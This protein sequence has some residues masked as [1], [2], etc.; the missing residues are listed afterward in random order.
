MYRM[1]K[2]LNSGINSTYT[3]GQNAE[4]DST[5]VQSVCV[6]KNMR[7]PQQTLTT[8]DL[9]TVSQKVVYWQALAR[10][11]GLTEPDIV[12]I[13]ANYRHD[14]NEQKYQ[15]V[16][17][18]FQQQRSLPTRQILVR[19]IEEKLQDFQLARDVASALVTVDTL[20]D[21]D[22]PRAHSMMT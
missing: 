18:W 20:S 10:K 17:K 13:E 16:L 9:V 14:Y 15:S 19:V 21:S 4:T 5:T 12:A 6:W 1:I 11:L 2:R 22:R 8:A 7:N 3:A